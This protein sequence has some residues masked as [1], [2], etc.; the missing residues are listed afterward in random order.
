MSL[1]TSRNPPPSPSRG[2]ELRLHA[3]L[4]GRVGPARIDAQRIATAAAVI[5]L[6]PGRC[7]TVSRHPDLGESYLPGCP[8]CGGAGALWVSHLGMTADPLTDEP[9]RHMAK[10]SSGG[11]LRAHSRHFEERARAGSTPPAAARW[12]PTASCPAAPSA[13]V[14]RGQISS[15]A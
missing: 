4:A 10:C 3:R 12:R 5:S 7:R 8:S 13:G 1:S 9:R 2:P 6:P 14:P 11:C 15:W